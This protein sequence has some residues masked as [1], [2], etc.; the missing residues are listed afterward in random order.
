MRREETAGLGHGHDRP[1]RVTSASAE[2]LAVALRQTKRIAGPASADRNGVHMRVESETGS[3]AIVD[4]PDDIGAAVRDR[5]NL[6]GKADG[7]ELG[8]EKRGGLDLPSRRVLRVDGDE[9]FKKAGEASD[10]GRGREGRKAHCTFPL[11]ATS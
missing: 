5:A 7:L 4:S 3:V 8:R 6:G 1:L 2:K 10:I 11:A 9:P